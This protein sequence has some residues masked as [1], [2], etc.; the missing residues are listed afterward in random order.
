[1]NVY[2]YYDKQKEYLK[3]NLPETSDITLVDSMDEA[4][5]IVSG[6]FTEADHHT[7]LKG[8]IIPFTGHN[9]IDLA[10]LRRHDLM[11]FN[12]TVHSVY[13]AE[14]AMR[15]LLGIMGNLQI[16]HER[17]KDCDWS[18]RNS[19]SRLPWTTLINKRVG[20]Y[21]FGRI[22]RHLKAM[23][24]PFTTEVLTI[25]RGKD[26]GDAILVNDL[27]GL[28]E[29]SDAIVICAPLNRYTED[30]FDADI[31]A[32]MHGMFL[33]NV[34]RGAIVNQ[35]ALYDALKD[36]TL[37]GYASDVWYNYPKNNEKKA[38]SDYPV[39]TLDNVLMTPHFG[40]FCDEA[41]NKMNAKVM[42]HLL[43]IEAGDFSEALDTEKLK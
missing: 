35:K 27:E 26:Y 30:A 6:R 21:G 12:T 25:D 10:A 20:I 34:G 18:N 40:G 3:N 33:V 37:Q 28:V 8:I 17:M 7:K 22:G 1:M 11:L 15:L 23:L 38:P 43:N 29:Q 19:E 36:G 14:M 24:A 32:R 16:Y 13:V 2:A 31:L 5:Y 9:G 41:P 39:H 4:E 42:N